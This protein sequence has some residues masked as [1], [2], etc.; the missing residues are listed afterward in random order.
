MRT[1]DMLTAVPT[2]VAGRHNLRVNIPGPEAWIMRKAWSRVPDWELWIERKGRLSRG[3]CQQR[4]DIES[5]LE[6]AF[7]AWWAGR[8]GHSPSMS[9][10]IAAVTDLSILR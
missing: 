5:R 8:S 4:L 10:M 7:C 2:P 9:S 6:P 1:N 3:Q